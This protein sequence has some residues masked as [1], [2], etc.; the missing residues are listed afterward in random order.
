MIFIYSGNINPGEKIQ[1]PGN[2]RIL[3]DNNKNKTYCELVYN[4]NRQVKS[5]KGLVKFL[6]KSNSIYITSLYKS[7]DYEGQ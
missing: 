1:Q 4:K 3:C 5:N 2:F 7:K 6:N